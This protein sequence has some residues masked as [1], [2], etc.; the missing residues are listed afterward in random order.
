MLFIITENKDILNKTLP[1][2]DELSI[3][4]SRSVK[5]LTD[6][7][8]V[9]SEDVVLLANGETV[10]SN[11]RK[12][13]PEQTTLIDLGK[14][15]GVE[16]LD[17]AYLFI[18]VLGRPRLGAYL[19][20]QS[21]LLNAAFVGSGNKGEV[22]S[23][24]VVNITENKNVTIEENNK[25][26]KSKPVA[27]KDPVKKVEK[28]IPTKKEPEIK[29]ETIEEEVVIKPKRK[30][31]VDTELEGVQEQL[32]SEG[33]PGKAVRKVEITYTDGVETGRKVLRDTFT[34]VKEPVPAKYIVSEEKDRMTPPNQKYFEKDMPR[35]AATKSEKKATVKQNT[36]KPVKATK[37]GTN[38]LGASIAKDEKPKDIAEEVP[39]FVD[40]TI[41]SSEQEQSNDFPTFVDVT[42]P[43]KTDSKQEDELPTFVD[44][45]S[46]S[47]NNTGSNEDDFPT[48]EDSIPSMF[49]TN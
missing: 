13:F 43:E 34:V 30:H 22:P 46:E 9:Q 35:P 48:F 33:I 31:L 40:E 26:V 18:K 20:D 47:S 41:N 10:N 25:K 29:K 38:R 1:F 5:E 7:R 24:S 12:K 4:Y 2:V 39:T 19:H 8:I 36:S 44:I 6:Y 3:V 15:G 21:N 27:K 11:V 16:N 42:T 32:L 45:D 14:N 17:L 23:A 28:D 49:R 37:I